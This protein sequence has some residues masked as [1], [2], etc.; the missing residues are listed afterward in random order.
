M[1]I[2][3]CPIPNNPS[4]LSKSSKHLK[5]SITRKKIPLGV[6]VTLGRHAITIS[7]YFRIFL[8][9][10][11]ISQILAG[12]S[13]LLS[14]KSITIIMQHN[15]KNRLAIIHQMGWITTRSRQLKWVPSSMLTH[16]ALRRF[17][18]LPLRGSQLRMVSLTIKF[19]HLFW[20]SNRRS[21]QPDPWRISYTRSRF[22]TT[23][24]KSV[25]QK[26]WFITVKRWWMR[27]LRDWIQFSFVASSGVIK[28]LTK[29]ATWWITWE[30]TLALSP[31]C[32]PCAINL[33]SRE[34]SCTNIWPSTKLTLTIKMM[35]ENF[36]T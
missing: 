2:S 1:H 31:S 11:I 33:S 9:L 4:S 8:L 20:I 26:V 5:V 17:S 35:A 21:P 18:F 19:K 12:N 6:T 34:H 13:S 28:N 23:V 29:N 14:R 7:Q 16:R 27:T 24:S 22:S 15:S 32:V 10:V 30:L 36:P 3:P 25:R